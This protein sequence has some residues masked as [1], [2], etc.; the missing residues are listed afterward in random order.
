MGRQ[1]KAEKEKLLEDGARI[2]RERFEGVPLIKMVATSVELRAFGHKTKWT[3]PPK[4]KRCASCGGLPPLNR[5]STVT[6]VVT[7]PQKL[8]R[9]LA[10]WLDEL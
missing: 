1:S 6:T 8:D 10:G 4:R 9:R 5:V 7:I 3:P 2:L